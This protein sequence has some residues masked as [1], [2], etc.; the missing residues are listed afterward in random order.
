MRLTLTGTHHVSTVTAQIG[1]ANAFLT[2][3]LG[4]RPLA[5]T[6]NQDAPTMYHLFFGDGAGTPGSEFTV[7]DIP[8]AARERRG[9]NRLSRTTFRVAGADALAW[10]AAHL[11][12]H[13]VPHGGLAE[14]DGRAVLDFEDPEGL[15]LSLVD[16]GGEGEA[17]PWAAS[18]VPAPYQLRG[19]GYVELTIPTLGPTDA[20]LTG[21][22]GLARDH[23]YPLP[24]APA[25]TVHVY[26]MG[27]AP[28]AGWRTAVA[29]EL[30]VVVRDDLPRTRPG[31]GGV[32]HVALRVPELAAMPAWDE[33]VGA[34][35]FRHSGLV[36]RHWFTSLYVREPNHVLFELATDAPGFALD[37]ADDGTRLIL[38]PFLE[39]R[40]AQIEDALVPLAT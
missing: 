19:L 21:T 32:H 37:D 1:R 5:R 8:R 38:P 22:L 9:N 20:F 26:R 35:G 6:V 12:A 15:E 18:P 36:D 17:F 28:A 13:G 16:D 23:A 24:H 7:F 25:F 3:V 10:W 4:L 39:P 30:H 11:D 33:H 14:R 27:D 40:R 2:G 34:Q 31:A 29:R